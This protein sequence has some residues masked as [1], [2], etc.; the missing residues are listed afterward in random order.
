MLCHGVKVNVVYKNHGFKIWQCVSSC[1][2]SAVVASQEAD[3]TQ[4]RLPAREETCSQLTARQNYKSD[5]L[6]GF[7]DGN[8]PFREEI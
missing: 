5:H 6:R 1:V 4:C 8:R 3:Y 7:M 2:L